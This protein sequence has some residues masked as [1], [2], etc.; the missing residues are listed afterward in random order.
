MFRRPLD[1]SLLENYFWSY[2][3][4]A[5]TL[6]EGIDIL[7]K[8]DASTFAPVVSRPDTYFG[9]PDRNDVSRFIKK[10]LRLA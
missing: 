2:C 6:A 8:S 9:M 10:G 1:A 3:V 7:E 4:A 5:W